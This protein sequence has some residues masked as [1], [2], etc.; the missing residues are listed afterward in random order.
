[1]TLPGEWLD[2]YL[3]ATGLGARLALLSGRFPESPSSVEAGLERSL[4]AQWLFQRVPLPESLEARMLVGF[5]ALDGELLVRSAGPGCGST[6]LELRSAGTRAALLGAIRTAWSRAWSSR[7][8]GVPDGYAV[9]VVRRDSVSAGELA[10][11]DRYSERLTDG[12]LLGMDPRDL[13]PVLES[14]AAGSDT[15]IPL[16]EIGA[17][18]RYALGCDYNRA[19]APENPYEFL[20]LLSARGEAGGRLRLRYLSPGRAGGGSGARA[21][22]ELALRSL[23]LEAIADERDGIDSLSGAGRPAPAPRPPVPGDTAPGTGSYLPGSPP[24]AG[25]RERVHAQQLTGSPSSPGRADGMLYR[26]RPQAPGTGM[27]RAGAVAL[28]CE[29]FHRGHLALEPVA[30]IETLGG[31]LGSGAHLAR[32]AGLP[33]V[34]GVRDALLLPEG[35][36]VRV[37]G[38]LGLVSIKAPGI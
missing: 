34:S 32:E 15:S 8:G 26:A 35:V 16:S 1:V 10:L 18:A 22:L 12:R 38:G 37:D 11:V 3:S 25:R 14:A 9:A 23:E 29:R 17:F 21:R 27:P 31:R 4:E 6:G 2:E 19:L 33:C 20:D 5:D 30:V 28:A 13:G 36:A 24:P 7:P